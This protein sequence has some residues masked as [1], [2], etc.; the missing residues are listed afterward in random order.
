MQAKYVAGKTPTMFTNDAK[1]ASTNRNL[2]PAQFE[3]ERSASRKSA[4]V[5][6]AYC[7]SAQRRMAPRRL[8]FT[9][10]TP[11]ND[12]P[13]RSAPLRS[14][15]LRSPEM[16]HPRKSR[17]LKSCSRSADSKA[18]AIAFRLIAAFCGRSE[19]INVTLSVH[20]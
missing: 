3:C 6:S 1:R 7:R 13:L 17:P 2:Q 9:S 15:P 18:F 14:R 5:K 11:T 19:S 16:E 8:A 10:L 12:E 20:T 4:S